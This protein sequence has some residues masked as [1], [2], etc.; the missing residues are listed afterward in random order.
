MYNNASIINTNRKNS[1]KRHNTVLPMT[2]GVLSIVLFMIGHLYGSFAVLYL[3]TLAMIANYT[4]FSDDL[5]CF[6]LLYIPLVSILKL[7]PSGASLVSYISL[8]GLALYFIKKK[9]SSVD[10]LII[11][12]AFGLLCLIFFKEL[13]QHFGITMVYI[14]LII[15]MVSTAIFAK[16]KASDPST[17][18]EEMRKANLFLT[19]GVIIASII[20]YTFMNN[21]RLSQFATVDSGYI[22]EEIVTRFAGVSGDPNYYSSLVIFAIASNLFQ[23]IHRPHIS[24]IVFSVIL[25]LF[26]LLSLSK[27][28]LILLTIVVLL[29]AFSWIKSNGIKD[30][31]SIITTFGIIACLGVAFHF[32]VN[33]S[34]VQLILARMGEDS[35]LNDFTTGRSD[36]W[37][38][39]IDVLWN[40]LEYFFIGTNSHSAIV[41]LH[42][43][44]NT[45][46]Q[47]WWKLGLIGIIFVFMWFISVWGNCNKKKVVGST[48]LF[49]GSIGATM[50]LD[51]LFFEQLFWFFAF[52]VI[53]KNVTGVPK[54]K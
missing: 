31:K 16:L 40:N 17:D 19:T 9:A 49:V 37:I 41:G 20:G 53:C 18:S 2:T 38:G 30:S 44:H 21:P 32:I 3:G 43:T 27:M 11:F 7:S 1:I 48:L 15:T 14:K 50:A 33:T 23:F 26:G 28:F 8:V 4:F 12:S 52:Y 29:F 22:G 54:N 25:T 45:I 51:I 24:N 46:I 6:E 5:L 36:A 39:Y 34:S 35:S 42:N 10:C 47:T 13:L